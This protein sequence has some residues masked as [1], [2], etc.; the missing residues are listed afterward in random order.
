[1]AERAFAVGT[2]VADEPLL[3]VD[4]GAPFPAGDTVLTIGSPKIYLVGLRTFNPPLKLSVSVPVR[5]TRTADGAE[6]HS[7][8]LR[9]S[10]P[11]QAQYL[12]WAKDGGSLLRTEL[13]RAPDAL[14]A[15]IVE[16]SLL[17]HLLPEHRLWKPAP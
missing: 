13:A 15:R 8:R 4:I 16:E 1:V 3:L 12:D 2:S 10:S 7:F 9:W 6:L 14:A 5:L 11:T 17:L